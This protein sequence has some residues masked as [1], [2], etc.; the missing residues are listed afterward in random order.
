MGE[1]GNSQK[2][3]KT[4]MGQKNISKMRRGFIQF[5]WLQ[6]IKKSRRKAM[7]PTVNKTSQNKI[8]YKCQKRGKAREPEG[9]NWYPRR[10]EVV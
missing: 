6:E 2:I 10:G 3:L 7:G 8:L 9:Q 1:Q 4:H 5:T